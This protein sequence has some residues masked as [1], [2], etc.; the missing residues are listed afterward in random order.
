MLHNISDSKSHRLWLCC[1]LPRKL[2]VA[3]L[4][5]VV[6]HSVCKTF[7]NVVQYLPDQSQLYQSHFNNNS[8]SATHPQCGILVSLADYPVIHVISREADNDITKGRA[9]K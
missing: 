3:G 8:T 5:P 9:I 6:L 7:K 2:V 1:Q 4:S